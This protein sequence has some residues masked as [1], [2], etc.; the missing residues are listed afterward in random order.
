MSQRI[1]ATFE[2]GVFKPEQRLELPAR[3]RV[4]LTVDLLENE[5][6]NTDEAWEGLEKL[7]EETPV[8]SGGEPLTR[9]Q[10]HERH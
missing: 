9:D 2:D 6:Q 7:W 10:M 1:L 3:A 5:T 4:R 8:D